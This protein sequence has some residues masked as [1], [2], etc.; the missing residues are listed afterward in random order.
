MSSSLMNVFLDVE[1]GGLDPKVCGVTEIGV[2]A[3]VMN[4]GREMIPQAANAWL[5]QPM[6][7]KVYE[8]AAL[9]MQGRTLDDLGHY[10]QDPL[11]AYEGLASFL[12]EYLGEQG[13][14]NNHWLGRIWTH[15]ADFD[16]RFVQQF[17]RDVRPDIQPAYDAKYEPTTRHGSW[18]FHERDYFSCTKR[19]W[20]NL[21][22]MGFHTQEK[23]NLEF[24]GKYLGIADIQEHH[25]LSDCA[26]G[27]KVLSAMTRMVR[28]YWEI[29]Q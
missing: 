18:M 4:L 13:E 19:E 7:S 28:E 26:T 11:T 3:F 17:E 21:R 6:E 22:G 8:E 15:N 1:T 12:R 2:I 14:K 10:G 16:F 20:V 25:T 23:S 9:K 27:I 24:I 5:I 29:V